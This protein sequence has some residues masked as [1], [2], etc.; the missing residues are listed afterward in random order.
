[1]L[2]L[3]YRQEQQIVEIFHHSCKHTTWQ[4]HRQRKIVEKTFYIL[5]G[6]TEY[7]AEASFILQLH[8]TGRPNGLT[9]LKESS[10]VQKDLN[11]FCYGLY[12][13]DSPKPHEPIGAVFGR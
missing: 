2:P 5:Q 11:Y 13:H 3:C 1:M 9:E 10:D 6:F 7:Q 12:L 4:R 8:S